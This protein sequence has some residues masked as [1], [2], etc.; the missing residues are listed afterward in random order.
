MHKVY[1]MY[2]YN[3]HNSSSVYKELCFLQKKKVQY[4]IVRRSTLNLRSL[5]IHS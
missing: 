5:V 3:V 1:K 4:F 2:M